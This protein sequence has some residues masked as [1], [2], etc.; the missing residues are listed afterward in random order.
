MHPKMPHIRLVEAR[1][2]HEKGEHGRQTGLVV[3]AVRSQFR[4]VDDAGDVRARVVHY[5]AMTAMEAADLGGR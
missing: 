4:W 3:V 2:A 5:Y 1:K